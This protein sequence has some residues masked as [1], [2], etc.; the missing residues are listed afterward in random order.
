MALKSVCLVHDV[1]FQAKAKSV[2]GLKEDISARRQAVLCDLLY[3]TRQ[4]AK[5]SDL[6][7]NSLYLQNRT[8]CVSLHSR[9]M[10]E[11]EHDLLF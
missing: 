2:E 5:L 11:G 9:L 4:N 8:Y 10:D 3:D 7:Q 6:E 1:P